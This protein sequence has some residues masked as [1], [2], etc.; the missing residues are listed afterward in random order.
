MSNSPSPLW[1]GPR[2]QDPSSV[3][4]D[5]SLDNN[6]RPSNNPHPQGNDARH[7]HRH[8]SEVH[9]QGFGP[10]IPFQ[11]VF[12]K[13]TPT[14]HRA[15]RLT[16]PAEHLYSSGSYTRQPRRS[17]Y[18]QHPPPHNGIPDYRMPPYNASAPKMGPTY[19]QPGYRPYGNES[20]IGDSLHSRPAFPDNA[21]YVNNHHYAPRPDGY[22]LPGSSLPIRGHN[23]SE[24]FEPHAYARHYNNTHGDSSVLN[25]GDRLMYPTT[26]DPPCQMHG[27][28]GRLSGKEWPKAGGMGLPGR[29]AYQVVDSC[30]PAHAQLHKRTTHQPPEH[31]KPEQTHGLAPTP[32]QSAHTRSTS[33]FYTDTVTQNDNSNVGELHTETNVNVHQRSVEGKREHEDA[34][35]GKYTPSVTQPSSTPAMNKELSKNDRAQQ[36]CRQTQ[37][38][39]QTQPGPLTLPL[40]QRETTSLDAS[41]NVQDHL[42]TNICKQSQSHGMQ[43]PTTPVNKNVLPPR[44]NKGKLSEP[45]H[46]A[47]H[48]RRPVRNDGLRLKKL[49]AKKGTSKAYKNGGATH[50]K[51][52]G[53]G[54]NIHTQRKIATG[55]KVLNKKELDEHKRLLAATTKALDLHPVLATYYHL[56]SD[57]LKIE[58]KS[59]DE[60]GIQLLRNKSVESL[61]YEDFL[62]I[63]ATASRKN[64]QLQ[65]SFEKNRRPFWHGDTI[66]LTRTTLKHGVR[67]SR[68]TVRKCIHGQMIADVVECPHDILSGKWNIYRLQSSIALQRVNE[69]LKYFTANTYNGPE[70]LR[71]LIVPSG[72]YTLSNGTQAIDAALDNTAKNTARKPRGSGGD[73]NLPVSCT[74][75][76]VW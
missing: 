6:D 2:H 61:L 41:M 44:V 9:N 46:K 15:R 7:I 62:V 36:S 14:F 17:P 29:D 66:F 4:A 45:L 43:Q 54:S 16:G 31:V 52:S 68:G 21:G 56:W 5:G 19:T 12:G 33:T 58:A 22:G 72:I 74:H 64:K 75:R 49:N 65:F 27:K 35:T 71:T 67:I 57:V 63:G 11:R 51:H 40:A 32:D 42:R 30:T 18:P 20:Y 50:V 28:I 23:M 38:E 34:R 8:I 76:Y 47:E 59:A 55:E 10:R 3:T 53:P 69:A 39:Q 25:G 13:D 24:M 48:A 1:N 26:R 37:V 73:V 70:W 60:R